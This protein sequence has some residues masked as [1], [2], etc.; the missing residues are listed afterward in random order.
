MFVKFF[1]LYSQ[2]ALFE[3]LVPYLLPHTRR[4]SNLRSLNTSSLTMS[5]PSW[6]WSRDALLRYAE[7]DAVCWIDHAE[8]PCA[9]AVSYT[10]LV[11]MVDRVAAIIASAAGRAAGVGLC[12]DNSLSAVVCHLG[13]LWVGNHFVPLDEPSAQ[14]RLQDMLC[15]SREIETIICSPHLAAAF[16]AVVR[17]CGRSIS[18]LVLDDA[19]LLHKDS[20]GATAALPPG[21]STAALPPGASTAALPP[22]ASTALP[23]QRACTYHT[24]GTTGTPKA[25]HST[26]EQWGAFVCAAARPYRL[27][28]ASRVFV[29]TSAIFDPSAGLTFAALA[30]GAAACL[31]PWSFTLRQLRRSVE[32]TRATHACSTPSVWALYDLESGSGAGSLTTLLLGG[33]PMP[34]ALTRA[35]LGLGVALINTY[36]TTEATV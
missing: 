1:A 15:A 5:P 33:E 29:A 2:L 20:S 9:R 27:T 30:V 24:S 25:I 35:W 32:L 23:S 11:D 31:A 14:P 4:Q 10:E 18:V 13:A 36:G 34:A 7:A 17:A 8:P 16:E 12:L 19:A 22:G 28:A 26:L 21:A 6:P 3:L